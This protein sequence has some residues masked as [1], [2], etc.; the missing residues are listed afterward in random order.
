M[1]LAA[2]TKLGPYEILSPLGAGGMGEV[3]KARDTRLERTVAVK[4]LPTHMSASPEVRQRF[5]REA[6]TISQLSHPHICAL[7]DVG[8]QN[9]VEFLVMELLEGET[10][11]DRLAKGPL[12]LEQALRYGQ[13]IADALDKAHRQGIVHR[14]LKPGNVM[15]TKSGAKLL[16]FGLAKAMAPPEAK[17][18]LTSLPTQQGLTQEGTILGTFQ[19]MAPEQLEGKDADARTDI[20][21]FGATLYEM[22]TGNKAFSGSTQASL[23]GAILHTE[24]APISQ[25][26]PMSPPALDRVVK[27]CLAKDPEERWQSA[28]DAGRELKWIAEGSQAGAPVPLVTRRKTRERLAWA[29]VGASLLAALGHAVVHFREAPAEP[30]PIRFFVFPPELTTLRG[31]PAAPQAAVSPDGRYLAFAATALDKTNQLWVRPLDSVVAQKLAG[32]EDASFPFWSPDSRFIGFFTPGKL[33]K[34]GVSGGPPQALCDAPEGNGGTWSRDGV[35]VFAP[36]REGVLARVSAT[37]GIPAPVTA[38]DRRRQETAHVWPQFLPDGRHFLY[39]RLSGRR[40]N[41]GLYVRSLAS[42]EAGLVLRTEVRAAYTPPGYLLFVQQG[43]LMAQRFDPNRLQ[44]TDEPVRVAEQVAYN[45]S[46]GRT[47]FSVSENGVIAYRTGLVGG[48]PMGELVWYDRG[49]KRIGPAGAPGLYLRPALSPDGKSVAVQRRDPQ[50]GTDDIWLVDL[51]RST[52]SRLTFGSS[53]QTHPTWSPDGSR[54]AF[55]SDQDGLSNLY[56]K[57][58]SGAGSE[59]LLLSSDTSKYVTDWS[60]DGRYIAY[61]NQ[62][63][64]TG[65]D[66]WV[67]PL[68]GDRK[69]IPYL[70]T[71]FNEAQGQFSPDGRWM[72]Y[73]SNE[74]GRTEVYVQAFPASGGKWQ[75]STAGGSFPRWRRDGKELFYRTADQKLMAVAVQTDSTFQAGQPR[76]LFETRTSEVPVIP[77]AVSADGQRFLVNTAIEDTNTSPITVVLNWIAEVAK[78]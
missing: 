20:F 41:R 12:P 27:T 51:A 13:E 68:S 65:S 61:E 24:P 46:N 71:E 18:S 14:D 10:L 62:G 48:V 43:T 75:I 1:S 67:L 78:K 56:Q 11:S 49:G 33:K 22:A 2:G 74:S 15:L 16:D 30:R 9:D 59:E 28:A 64:G 25:R 35:I 36:N 47:T 19:Y 23:I 32:T 37:G 76:A 60:L 63:P 57:I 73:S 38:L 5:E 58:S 7:Y 39:L 77:Y 26:Q 6:K 70:R 3:Y 40:E 55:A 44:L 52:V 34:V 69:P 72:A 66:L 45:P 50:T 21:A 53:N 4:V 42:E 54:I 31:G 17:S 8:R 29:L